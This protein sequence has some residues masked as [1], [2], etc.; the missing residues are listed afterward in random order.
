[1]EKIVTEYL[2]KLKIPISKKYVEKLLLSHTDYP[3]LLSIS[4][5]LERLGIE[6][7][8]GK[9]APEKLKEIEFPYLIHTEN[10]GGEFLLIKNA[11]D[12]AKHPEVLKT[13]KGILLKV[14]PTNKI[15]DKESNEVFSDER[16]L[17]A[18]TGTLFLALAALLIIVLSL[19]FSL[20]NSLLVALTVVGIVMGYFLVA[21]E[22]GIKY[23][24]VE[25]FCGAAK[26]VNCDAV[27]RSDYSTVFGRFKVSD[28]VLSY[29]L[30]QVMILGLL[31]PLLNNPAPFYMILGV[32]SVCTMPVVGLS[33]YY[34][35]AKLKIWCRLCLAV[36]ALLVI[37]TGMFIYA[38]YTNA[39]TTESFNLI[40]AFISGLSFIAITSA[41]IL[42][43]EKSV[44]VN[45]A[46]QNEMQANRIKLN[47]QLFTHLLFKERQINT[48]AFEKEIRIGNADAPIQLLM[49]SNLFCNPCKMMHEKLTELINM[50]PEKVSLSIRILPVNMQ[51]KEEVNPR[52]YFIGYWLNHISGKKNESLNTSNLITD[53]FSTKNIQVFMSQYQ[54]DVANNM[55]TE[56]SEILKKHTEWVDT[57]QITKTPTLFLNG[58]ELPN[59][60]GVDDLKSM[61]P[62]LA[63]A[64][65]YNDK[66]GSNTKI[67]QE[68]VL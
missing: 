18:I 11:D 16:F 41:V 4:D 35:F 17:N 22:L 43:K 13:W 46:M 52:N 10:R 44:S 47:P 12:I 15:R 28:L 38:F 24:A 9:T 30:F 23:K 6:T 42:I 53:W 33:I 19:S 48:T 62:G 56:L 14:K 50:Y 32:V 68:I 8:I 65:Q 5:V 34:Q 57:S 31:V 39:I 64:L 59:G 49:A 20:F 51:N 21:K 37:Q 55:D 26:T 2:S 63:G 45:K 7:K 60:Y 25:S 61:I 36:A 66:L 3:S 40:A 54:M 58:Y 27:I 67:Q 29:F 1:M